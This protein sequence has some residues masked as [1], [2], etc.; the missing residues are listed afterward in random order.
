MAVLNA[1]NEGIVYWLA[2]VIED[3]GRDS[4]L[5]VLEGFFV[6]VG[7]LGL[8]AHRVIV[9]LLVVVTNAATVQVYPKWCFI[10]GV[11]IS[12]I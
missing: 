10:I 12:R 7:V 11:A 1:A 2:A 3:A 9:T 6:V 8:V 4:V 5:Q